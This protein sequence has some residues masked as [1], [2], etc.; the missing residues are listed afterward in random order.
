MTA[1]TPL[2]PATSVFFQIGSYLKTSNTD[3]LAYLWILIIPSTIGG[4]LGGILM[5]KIYEPLL[6]TIKF[7]D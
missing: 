6:L 1:D 2:N 7:K 4:I 3:Y 5:H